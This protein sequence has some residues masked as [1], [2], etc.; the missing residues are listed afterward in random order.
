MFC[1]VYR[2][3]RNELSYRVDAARW[4]E[5]RG[6]LAGLLVLIGLGAANPASSAG[7]RPLLI[8]NSTSAELAQGE[9]VRV[10]L[11]LGLAS[12]C[13]AGTGKESWNE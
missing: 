7:E 3:G 11:R 10:S 12:R 4:G 9:R 2:A 5:F 1:V 13:R 6:V 8:R